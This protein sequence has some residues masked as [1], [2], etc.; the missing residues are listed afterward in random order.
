MARAGELTRGE[1]GR[2][3]RDPEFLKLWIST[4]ISGLGSAVTGLALPLTA[5][6]LLSATPTQMGLLGAFAGA[7]IL[8]VG[9]LAGVW[10]DRLPRRAILIAADLGQAMLLTTIPLAAT[11]GLLQ[12]EQLYLVGFL[13]GTLAVFADV[14]GT[15]YLPAVVGRERLVEGNAGIAL[16]GAVASSAGPGLAGLLIQIITAPLALLVDAASFLASAVLRAAMRTDEAPPVP[17]GERGS[18]RT[19]IAE[20]VRAVFGDPILRAM[21]ISSTIGHLA[22]TVQ[23]TVLVLYLTRDLGLAPAVIGAVFASRGVA[24][25]A[26]TAAAGPWARRFGPGSAIIGGTSLVALGALILP[27]AGVPRIEDTP[28]LTLAVLLLSHTLIGVGTPIYS[29]SQATV[30]QQV[31]QDRLLGR[32]NASRRVLVFGAAPLGALHAGTL[33]EVIGL[34]ATLLVGG[35]LM[36]AALAWAYASPLRALRIS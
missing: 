35:M 10:V 12:M 24:S 19:E 3:W 5:I 22:L 27:A 33:G 13:G 26:A 29:V 9:L 21:T 32:V 34:H 2:L 25:L 11:L 18:V 1:K 30:R 28:F 14:A 16:T 17:R 8:L 31:T 23:G 7:P 36:A 20:G 4:T 6:L 15:S